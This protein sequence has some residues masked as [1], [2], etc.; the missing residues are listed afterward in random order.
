MVEALL[1]CGP[2]EPRHAPERGNRGSLSRIGLQTRALDG[3]A[4]SS[5]TWTCPPI[6]RGR[7]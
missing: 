3:C 6:G 1:G 2:Q 5:A 7:Y 4:L